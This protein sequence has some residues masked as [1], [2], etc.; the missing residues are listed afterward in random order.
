[1]RASI[2]ILARARTP[3]ALIGAFQLA[4]TEIHLAQLSNIDS[5]VTSISTRTVVTAR[6]K[7]RDEMKR[8]RHKKS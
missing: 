6:T 4:G 1:M 7:P 2:F 5:A 8:A 3:R